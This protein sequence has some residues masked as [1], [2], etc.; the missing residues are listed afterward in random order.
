M[1][2]ELANIF[3]KAR[4]N[5]QLGIKCVLATV[6]HLEGSSYRKPGVRML[7]CENGSMTGA[8]SGGC[9]EN[10]IKRRASSVF[11]DGSPKVI[12]YD[13]RYRLGCEGILHIL[14]EPIRISDAFLNYFEGVLK[15][16]AVFKIDSY[17]EIGDEITGHFGSTIHFENRSFKLYNDSEIHHQ[18]DL[19]IFSQ[20][21]NPLFRLMII[22]AE[23]D[24]AKLCETA[25]LLGWEVTIITSAKN[26][27]EL[28][29]FP[30]A[31]FVKYQEPEL[32]EKN[33]D[34]YTAVV[35]MNHNYALD[36][37]Y[38]LR[39]HQEKIRYLGVLGSAKRREQLKN[40][41]LN[42]ASNIDLDFFESIYSP[43]GLNIG[44]ITPEEIGLSIVSEIL[45]VFRD[46]EA[47]SLREIAK[48][49]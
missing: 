30:G 24:A 4:I 47:Y 10:E 43:A 9:V 38:L 5:D 48:Y 8:V 27:K 32:L 7:I 16:R 15:K 13:G 14:I 44:A 20:N 46:K 23:H 1:T 3:Q 25:S 11:S 18:D 29:D 34:E 36:L 41:L 28:K 26:P 39:L 40:D 33:I 6:V 45:S 37:K 49:N 2:H 19:Q 42:Y 12:S 21:L 35:L 31:K 22:G 17:Y